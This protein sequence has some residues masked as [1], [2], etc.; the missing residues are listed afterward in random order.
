MDSE[1]STNEAHPP[2][3]NREQGEERSVPGFTYGDR[4][5]GLLTRELRLPRLELPP[6]PTLS[7]ARNHATQ[8][9]VAPPP[10]FARRPVQPIRPAAPT[11]LAHQPADADTAS[12]ASVD[13]RSAPIEVMPAQPEPVAAISV[14][15]SPMPQPAPSV[16]HIHAQSQ[17]T[18]RSLAEALRLLYCALGLKAAIVVAEL[19]GAAQSGSLAMLTDA[20][21]LSI[22]VFAIG[23]AIYAASVAMRP[24]N[25]HAPGTS[26]VEITAVRIN[27][28]VLMIAGSEIVLEAFERLGEPPELAGMGLAI[29][30]AIIRLVVSYVTA[31]MLARRAK[32]NLN[33]KAVHM[34]AR[35]D[36]MSSAALI[37]S[38]IVV[39]ST[40]ITA[41]DSLLSIAV[42][43][44]I[45]RNGWNLLAHSADM[46]ARLCP[47][48]SA[49]HEP[50]TRTP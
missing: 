10:T 31:S 26:P 7:R 8:R 9:D 42:A 36:M 23:T 14:P 25:L 33:L 4:P 21:H 32:T 19:Y 28:I 41:V 49:Q 5:S 34:H 37:I 24:G 38:A 35:A 29:G 45:L 22:D 47:T 3:A 40:G 12:V 50:Q 44:I 39:S 1:C 13:Q 30:I 27:G 18:A 15:V 2:P 20:I 16:A 46:A 6:V 43:Y 48:C 11:P 17:Q